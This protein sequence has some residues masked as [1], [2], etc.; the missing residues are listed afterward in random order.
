MFKYPITLLVLLMTQFSVIAQDTTLQ[1]AKYIITKS[2]H[3]GADLTRFD[4][5][6]GGEFIFEFKNKVLVNFINNSSIDTTYSFGPVLNVK[7]DSLTK[8]NDFEKQTWTRFKWY[9][10]NSYDSVTGYANIDFIVKETNFETRFYLKM[11]I[12]KLKSITEYWGY[13]EGK[14]NEYIIDE[15]IF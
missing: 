11:S 4:V 9:F 6:R 7:L 12:P 14:K 1:R 8:K 5:G 3:N 13:Q 15:T 10:K 2:V